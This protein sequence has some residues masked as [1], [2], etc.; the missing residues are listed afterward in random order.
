MSVKIH[1]GLSWLFLNILNSIRVSLSF[2]CVK[3]DE[4]SSIKLNS[5]CSYRKAS[6]GLGGY[7]RLNDINYIELLQ[8]F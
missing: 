7:R 2:R 1:V 5:F 3:T 4:Y 6:A 8:A